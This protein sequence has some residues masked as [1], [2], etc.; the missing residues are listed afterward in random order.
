[1]YV[2]WRSAGSG[3]AGRPDC[4]H[5][6]CAWQHFATSIWCARSVL[7][8]FLFPGRVHIPISHTYTYAQA[9]SIHAASAPDRVRGRGRVCIVVPTGRPAGP[10]RRL[11]PPRIPR[12][13]RSS[14]SSVPR[15]QIKKRT[16]TERGVRALPFG[17]LTPAPIKNKTP[18]AASEVT[19]ATAN[20]GA[21][22][23]AVT[24][25]AAA[26][27]VAG[28]TGTAVAV[29]GTAGM[30]VVVAEAAAAA[31]AALG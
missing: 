6:A 13:L 30:A 1:M 5:A 18:G 10:G 11:L 12:R 20:S 22:A 7:S 16:V 29:P 3:E 28:T 27:V 15:P 23:G 31:A 21:C 24:A 26:A 25:T 4:R 17:E 9:S 8:S 14:R 19:A 2:A